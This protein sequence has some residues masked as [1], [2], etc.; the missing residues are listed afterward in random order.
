[1]RV[2]RVRIV[3]QTP[4]LHLSVISRLI[5]VS[6]SHEA[7]YEAPCKFVV[8]CDIQH[9]NAERAID[10]ICEEFGLQADKKPLG[11]PEESTQMVYQ[12][13]AA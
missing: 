6:V 9:I 1:M 3:T 5:T 12:R 13:L 11:L 8:T 2:V 10:H 7:T 4:E